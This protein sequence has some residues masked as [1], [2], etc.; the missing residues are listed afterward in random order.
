VRRACL[1]GERSG[2]AAGE[3]RKARDWPKTV[4]DYAYPRGGSVQFRNT[5]TRAMCGHA[6]RRPPWRKRTGNW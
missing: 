3:T 1:G 4:S 6:L 5:H 2:R